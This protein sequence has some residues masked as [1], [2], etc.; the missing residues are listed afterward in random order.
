MKK[1]K[2][3]VGIFAFPLLASGC[4]PITNISDTTDGYIVRQTIDNIESTFDRFQNIQSQ[5]FVFGNDGLNKIVNTTIKF[6]KTTNGETTFKSMLGLSMLESFTHNKETNVYFYINEV[7]SSNP[8]MK[9]YSVTFVVTKGNNTD[10]SAPI[11]F[12]SKYSNNYEEIVQLSDFTKKNTVIGNSIDKF[13]EFKSSKSSSKLQEYY[14]NNKNSYLDIEVINE[15]LGIEFGDRYNFKRQVKIDWALTKIIVENEFS[16]LIV[17]IRFYGGETFDETI[18]YDRGEYCFPIFSDE[19][20]LSVQKHLFKLNEALMI[21]HFENNSTLYGDP[22]VASDGFTF[23][24]AALSTIGLKKYLPILIDFPIVH[25]VVAEMTINDL[26]VVI[27][28]SLNWI[29]TDNQN[30]ENTISHDINFI[31]EKTNQNLLEDIYKAF[32]INGDFSLISNHSTSELENQMNGITAGDF[33][34][35]VISKL[36]LV[37][38]NAIS[39]LIVNLDEMEFVVTKKDEIFVLRLKM[40][41]SNYFKEFNIKII[42]N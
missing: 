40:K 11:T 29:D 33:N 20:N 7:N 1:I 31:F 9:N 26:K 36:K 3:L 19:I 8:V 24:D 12:S 41:I 15:Q 18:S 37:I 6:H 14:D 17:N 21:W 27:N 5:K 22:L 2:T 25:K 4:G 16:I 42:T 32:L 39:D 38:P 34:S 13:N 30:E 35:A 10:K 23:D 28:V